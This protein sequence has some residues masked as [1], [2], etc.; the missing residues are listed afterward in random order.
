MRQLGAWM[1]AHR[2]LVQ[3]LLLAGTLIALFGASR[4]QIDDVPRSFYRSEDPEFVRL[5]QVFEDFGSDD[6]DCVVLLQGELFS[7]SA[8]TELQALDRDLASIAGVREVWSLADTWV[9]ENGLPH[10]LLPSAE[11]TQGQLQEAREAALRHPLLGGKILSLDGLSTVLVIRLENDSQAVSAVR[12]IVAAIE[13]RLE[14]SRKLGLTAGLTGVPAIS[15]EVFDR[16]EYEQGVFAIIGAVIGF[17]VGWALFRRPVPMLITSGASI[18]AGLWAVGTFG[19]IGRPMNIL[20]SGLPLL[21]MVIALTDAVHLMLD[22]A[23]SRSAGLSPAEASSSAIRHLGLPCALT[24]LTTAVGFGSLAVSRVSVIREFGLIFALAIVLSFI[25]VISSVPNLSQ[26]FLRVPDKTKPPEPRKL[27]APAAER[28]IRFVLARP[29]SVSVLGA[30]LTLALA[31]ACLELEPDNRLT[32]ASPRGSQRVETLV[33]AEDAFGG[34]LSASVLCEWNSEEVDASE[35]LDA[36]AEVQASMGS[37]DFFHGTLSVLDLLA[38][39][40]G[41]ASDSASATPGQD[42]EAGLGALQLFPSELVSR[43][44]RPDLGRALVSARVPDASNQEAE[45]A[46]GALNEK[47][48]TIRERF[49]QVSFELTG[50][51]VASRRIINFMI[52]DFAIGIAIA[53]AVIF[54]VLSVAFRSVRIGMLCILPNIFPVVATG[55][56]LAA[57]GRELQMTSV[58]AFTVCLGLAVDDTIHFV[59][60]YRRELERTR[61]PKEAAVAAFVHVGRALVVTTAILLGGFLAMAFSTVPTTQTFAGICT[62]GLVAALFGDLLFLPALLVAGAHPPRKD[63]PNVDLAGAKSPG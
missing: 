62:L 10:P 53:A 21:V 24:S 29:R 47:L 8:V 20:S 9:F 3:A 57:L 40:P 54:A 32:E 38:A 23:R 58:I 5:S 25:V 18:L 55:A 13:T 7:G 26:S 45:V 41:A 56:V 61:D 52:V 37:R 43:V 59:A 51:E 19:L 15:A 42:T 44:W 30:L 2:A 4:L 6:S 22:V 35:T 12:P 17:L 34:V 39:L 1:S 46:Y 27:S 33:A 16:I 63:G 31:V 36:I 14:A 11:A 49:P 60:R 48:D 50:T 28:V